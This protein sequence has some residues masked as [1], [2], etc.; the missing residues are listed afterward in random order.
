ME[1]KHVTAAELRE[2]FERCREQ[3]GREP[4]MV[5]D[6]DGDSVF[7]ISAADYR[8]YQDL[9]RRSGCAYGGAVTEEFQRDLD[10]IMERHEGV[11]AG[12]AKC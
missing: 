12:L 7:L 4:V 10:A 6:G 2:N 3:A 11:F 8:E 1:S 9:K 5:S